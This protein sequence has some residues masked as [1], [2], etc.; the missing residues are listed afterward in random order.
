M[1]VVAVALLQEVYHCTAV[2]VG[3]E[4]LYTYVQAIPS[5]VEMSFCML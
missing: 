3:F 4:V 1:V 5:D 2:E